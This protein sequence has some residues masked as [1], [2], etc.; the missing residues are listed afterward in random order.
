MISWLWFPSVGF[1]DKDQNQTSVRHI[2]TSY[3]VITGQAG[4]RGVSWRWVISLTSR[5]LSSSIR[6]RRT[7][8]LSITMFILRQIS[9]NHSD[10][11]KQLNKHQSDK[12]DLK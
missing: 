9:V 10:Q 5:E 12:K 3:E 6:C 1:R 7:R 11:E 4:T 2:A 8:Q